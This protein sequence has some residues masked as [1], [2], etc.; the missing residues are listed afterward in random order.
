MQVHGFICAG[1]LIAA[2]CSFYQYLCQRIRDHKR[3]FVFM[4]GSVVYMEQRS[5]SKGRTA[6]VPVF[7]YEYGGLDYY[8]IHN[9]STFLP[10]RFHSSLT[11]AFRVGSSVPLLVDQDDPE[12]ALV[13]DYSMH[14]HLWKCFVFLFMGIFV[15]VA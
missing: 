7:H 14:M 2:A 8:K 5:S 11:S 13:N 15:F 3:N 1:F 6:Y 10:S 12:Y 4:I 9:D